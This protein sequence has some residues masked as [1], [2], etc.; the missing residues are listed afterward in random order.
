MLSPKRTTWVVV[1]DGARAFIAANEGPGTG[2]TLVP[3]TALDHELHSTTE[4]GSERPGR[5]FTSARSGTRHGIEPRVDWHRFEKQK[6]A[7]GIA[8]L[9][10]AARASK[11]FHHLV[12]VAP[13]ET[14][15]ELRATLDK[16]TQAMVTGE[17]AKDLTRHP[18]DDL[19][20]HLAGL[21][22]V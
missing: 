9:L 12:L 20:S 19:P 4:M 7:H 22:K 21:V 11:A 8:K 17:V 14:L 6:F 2:L 13:P 10:D 5:S 3:G 15:G 16:Q 1:A 18:I